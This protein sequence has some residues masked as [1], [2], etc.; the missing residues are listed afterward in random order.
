[1]KVFRAS[2]GIAATTALAA[3]L[4]L[5]PTASALR[6]DVAGEICSITMNKEEIDL[7]LDA[8]LAYEATEILEDYPALTTEL[9]DF[10]AYVKTTSDDEAIVQ[11]RIDVIAG[12]N[13]SLE[14]DLENYSDMQF[15]PRP[16]VLSFPP[17]PG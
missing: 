12:G 16:P 5:S 6:V 17:A 7:Y 10:F 3:S 2:L 15:E 8:M 1:M 9:N 11:A 13:A 14:R 4:L